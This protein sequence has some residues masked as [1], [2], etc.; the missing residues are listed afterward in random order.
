MESYEQPAAYFWN[1][2]CSFSKL[3]ISLRFN[4]LYLYYVITAFVDDNKLIL[5]II[6]QR[7]KIIVQFICKKYHF[8]L[9][10]AMCIGFNF[11]PLS[12]P[13]SLFPHL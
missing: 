8:I 10:A 4:M 3:L 9:F 1:K 2:L 13:Q 11:L 6:S 5:V 7:I 12:I